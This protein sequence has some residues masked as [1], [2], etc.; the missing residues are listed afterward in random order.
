[1]EKICSN[2]HCGGFVSGWWTKFQ[3]PIRQTIQF[4]D[5]LVSVIPFPENEHIASYNTYLT[6]LQGSALPWQQR[7]NSGEAV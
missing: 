6:S 3:V 1:M 4:E 2:S 7:R 5:K